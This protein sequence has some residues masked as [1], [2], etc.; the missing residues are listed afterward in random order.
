MHNNVQNNSRNLIE[1]FSFLSHTLNYI[2]F[3]QPSNS[4]PIKTIDSEQ[5]FGLSGRERTVKYQNVFRCIKFNFLQIT[6]SSECNSKNDYKCYSL[7]ILSNAY[8]SGK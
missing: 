3:T 6:I 7:L 1:A 2:M 4:I 8:V 5:L